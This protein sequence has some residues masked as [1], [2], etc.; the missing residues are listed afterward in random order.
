MCIVIFGPQAEA[1]GLHIWRSADA[2]N[3]VTIDYISVLA[4]GGVGVAGEQRQHIPP[5][6]DQYLVDVVGLYDLDGRDLI[7]QRFP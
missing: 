2:P 3:A 7:G 5:W 4:P 6:L 1:C